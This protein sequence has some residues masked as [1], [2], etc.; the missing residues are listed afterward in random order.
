MDGL[1]VGLLMIGESSVAGVL[2]QDS[3]SKISF[4]AYSSN[5]H[6]IFELAT[7]IILHKLDTSTDW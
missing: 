4:I 1:G 6:L 2:G 7:L 3:S 5:I